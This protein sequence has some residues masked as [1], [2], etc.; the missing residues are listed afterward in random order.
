MIIHQEVLRLIDP[1]SPTRINI[2]VPYEGDIQY[3]IEI[4][5]QILKQRR[6]PV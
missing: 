3:Q 5:V 6:F 1:Q 2:S 4:F